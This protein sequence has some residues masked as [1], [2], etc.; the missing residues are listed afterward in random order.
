MRTCYPGVA[1]NDCIA[2]L[3]K[4]DF[5]IEK[6]Y[7]NFSNSDHKISKS[8][9]LLQVGA[10]FLSSMNLGNRAGFRTLRAD[11]VADKVRGRVMSWPS[12]WN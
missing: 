12:F 2:M 8:C 1:G 7:A 3:E 6:W 4:K 9:K 5:G 10:S 11:E